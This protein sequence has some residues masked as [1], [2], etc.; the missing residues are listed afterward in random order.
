MYH[1]HPDT[2]TATLRGCYGIGTGQ[3][4][5]GLLGEAVC[6]TRH[7][8]AD[9]S[10]PLGAEVAG[11]AYPVGMNDLFLLAASIKDRKTFE[12]A[13]PWAVQADIEEKARYEV[14]PEEREQALRELDAEIKFTS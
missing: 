10:T 4:G 1:E 12:K 8:M 13:T 2:L 3:K 9:T 14:S 5:P 6:L 7:A 11:W